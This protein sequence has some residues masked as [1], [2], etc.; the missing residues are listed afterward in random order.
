MKPAIAP[1]KWPKN[2]IFGVKI[3]GNINIATSVKISVNFPPTSALFT[4]I[5]P[6]N[7][8][9]KPTVRWFVLGNA[10]CSA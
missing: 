2:E 8:P 7:I 1:E 9:E 4:T 6:N 10:V 5:N 3:L